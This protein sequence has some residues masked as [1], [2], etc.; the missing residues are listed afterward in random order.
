MSY[1]IG[2]LDKSP[3]AEGETATDALRRTIALAQ[4]AERRGFRRFW[5]AEHH[6]MDELA[7]SAPEILIPYLLA[8]TRTIRVGSGGVMLQHYSAYKVAESFNTLAAL[9]PGRLDLGIGKA[10]G[11]L[12]YSTLALQSER[13]A[14]APPDFKRQFAELTQFL[15]GE[16]GPD[17]PKATPRPVVTPERFL[18]GASV[19]SAELAAGQG[20]CFVFARHLNG[21]DEVLGASAAAYREASGQSPIVALAVILS[22]DRGEAEAQG[23]RF[24]PLKLH[25]AGRQSVTVAN[26]DVAHEYA[27]QA[28]AADYRIEPAVPSLVAGTAHDLIDELDQLHASHGIEEFIIDLG[29]QGDSRLTAVDLLADALAAAGRW[30]VPA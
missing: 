3:V 10:P 14:G 13:R 6:N 17:R 18:L 23:A 12:P 19:D 9:A 25:I 20:W 15:T 1:A 2:L 5:V 27:R 11:G 28:G 7:S 4:L 16:Q 26:E 8:S 29:N 24:Q 30:P 21:D 22:A